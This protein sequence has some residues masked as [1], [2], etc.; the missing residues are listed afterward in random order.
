MVQTTVTERKGY[1]V[2]KALDR[3]SSFFG[4]RGRFMVL[5]LLIAGAA[6]LFGITVNASFGSMMGLV[7]FGLLLFA[8]YMVIQTLQ[9]KFTEKEFSRLLARKQL[10]H[11]IKVHPDIT[12]NSIKGHISWK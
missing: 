8:D 1:R 12:F 10:P 2:W 11:Y 9:G 6:A 4:I 5:F 3:P 7:S